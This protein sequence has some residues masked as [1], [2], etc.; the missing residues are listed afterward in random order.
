MGVAGRFANDNHHNHAPHSPTLLMYVKV[1]ELLGAFAFSLQCGRTLVLPP[2][3]D[4]NTRGQPGL[5]LT[6]IEN[7]FDTRYTLPFGA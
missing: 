7:L 3:I 1:D 2:F 4:W 6:P 5:G